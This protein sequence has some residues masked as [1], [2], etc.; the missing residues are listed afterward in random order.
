MNLQQARHPTEM[1]FQPKVPN[2]VTVLASRPK[3]YPFSSQGKRR[4]LLS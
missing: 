2:P 4:K 1:H 3:L